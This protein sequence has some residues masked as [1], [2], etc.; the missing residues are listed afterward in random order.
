MILT[1]LGVNGPYPSVK[2]ACSG[3]LLT[4][5]SGRTK[6]LIDCGSGVLGRLLNE[7]TVRELNAVVLSH[8]HFDHM[9]D[10]LPMN[11]LLQ[12]AG[13]QSL[14]V[15]CPQTPDKVRRMLEDGA[16]DVYPVQD[17]VIGEMKL[18]FMRVTHP[19]ETYALRVFCDGKMFVYTGDT[20]ECDALALFSGDADLLLA[21]AG[22]LRDDWTIKKPHMTPGMCARLARDAGAKRLVLTHINPSYNVEAVLDEAVNDYP[23]AMVARAGVRISI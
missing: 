22:L 18:E 11:Y 17:T 8:L 7:C 20:N 5:D 19:V 9:S 15:L 1:M 10:M 16:L 21:D 13:V 12:A 3:Y 23:D 2:G 4:S 6:I 14:K